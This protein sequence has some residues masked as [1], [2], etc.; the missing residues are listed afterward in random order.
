M[1]ADSL[2]KIFEE[3]LLEDMI[4]KCE[5]E[6]VGKEITD[7]VMKIYDEAVKELLEVVERRLRA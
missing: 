1:N 4:Y 2:R 7:G 6:D 3:K 5:D